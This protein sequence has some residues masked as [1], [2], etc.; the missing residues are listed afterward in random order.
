MSLTH[1]HFGSNESPFSRRVLFRLES[2]AMDT[3]PSVQQKSGRASS[4]GESQT[5][6][7]QNHVNAILSATCRMLSRSLLLAVLSGATS[8]LEWQER[9]NYPSPG[10]HH[11]ITFANE[12]HA[13]L[14][15]GTTADALAATN[16]VW[17]YS[18]SDDRW[19]QL[20][21]DFPGPARS[22]GYG[23]VLPDT[24]FVEQSRF[25]YLGFGL[26]GQG[27]LLSDLWRFDM[28]T[29]DWEEL[30]P[31]PS[32]GRRHPA[33]V[34]VR[35]ANGGYQIHV[36][37]GDGAPGNLDDWW[38]YDIASDAWTQAPDFPSSARH[39]PFFFGLGPYSYAGL[40]HSD[41][42]TL[43][44]SFLGIPNI[45][46]DWYRFDGEAWEQEGDFESFAVVDGRKTETATTEA[47]V[48]GTQFAIE[49]PFLTEI[50]SDLSL[51]FVLS[52]DGDDHSVMPDGEF[53]A[54][55]PATANADSYWR[56]LPSHPGNSRWA[57][58]SFVM[59]GTTRAY[60]TSG[61]DR[62]TGEYYSDLW[63]MDLASLFPEG[64][65]A[66]V[67]SPAPQTDAPTEDTATTTTVPPT[68]VTATSPTTTPVTTTTTTASP[69]TM[70]FTSGA[71]TFGEVISFFVVL[72]SMMLLQ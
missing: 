14:L 43:V 19:S 57:P 56:Q 15:T 11:P 26:N 16:E 44:D 18:E 53:H 60:F 4:E 51:G 69:P 67:P 40:G 10:R 46:R 71:F 13:F 39:H 12:T 54:F 55:Y 8:A 31:L 5:H 62:A 70:S 58:G 9:P 59:R 47:R 6:N 24:S 2:P 72:G 3:I 68:P 45:E 34:P 52:G 37:L 7:I 20:P 41:A 1:S 32:F 21:A 65:A 64:S 50:D 66:T 29:Y 35:K 33:M 63:M 42:L 61:L 17:V 49:G 28:E 25:A 30:A 27:Q 36:G 38:V 48:A 23:V 22:F